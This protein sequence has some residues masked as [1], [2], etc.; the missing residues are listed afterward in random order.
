VSDTINFSGA[1]FWLDAALAVWLIGTSV[2]V[3]VSNKRKANQDE[4]DQL[5]KRTRDAE[6]RVLKLESINEYQP[7]NR[8]IGEIHSRVDQL[9]Q[10]LQNV[11]GQMIQINNTMNNINQHLLE[12]GKQ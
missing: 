5:N 8:E 1:S 11:E 7:G 3:W 2:F 6:D 12:R 10:G 4:I 9:G